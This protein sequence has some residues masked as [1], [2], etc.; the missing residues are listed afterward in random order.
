MD[1]TVVAVGAAVSGCFLQTATSLEIDQTGAPDALALRY[2]DFIE[3]A[4]DPV[5]AALVERHVAVRSNDLFADDAWTRH[6]FCRDVE[7]AFGLEAYMAAELVDDKG[8]R[9]VVGVARKAGAPP[10]S[11]LDAQWLQTICLHASV[12]LARLALGQR[13]VVPLSSL[14]PKQRELVRLVANGLTNDQIALACGVTRHAVKKGLAQLF[15]KADV[16]SR[17]ELV[18]CVQLP[19]P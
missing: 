8:P 14:T 7:A 19:E 1:C 12:A 5:H 15:A 9:G 10:F 16:A 4:V 18:A 2:A 17:A 13:I 3:V 6:P 11:A